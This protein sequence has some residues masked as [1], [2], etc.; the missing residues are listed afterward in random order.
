MK[1]FLEEPDNFQS[2]AGENGCTTNTFV[3]CS[4]TS[5][6]TRNVQEYC[7]I[8]LGILQFAHQ[9][10]ELMKLLTNRVPVDD[11]T[12]TIAE[13]VK[14]EDYHID[15]FSI[16]VSIPPVIVANEHAIG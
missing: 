12:L 6:E 2:N 1:S 3:R 7:S 4:N 16:E 14:K 5:K 13:L 11:F 15:G 10:Q 8:C 9:D